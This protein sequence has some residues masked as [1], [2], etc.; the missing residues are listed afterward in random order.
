M[1]NL[2]LNLMSKILALN[3]RSEDQD[4]FQ[5]LDILY[6]YV[7]VMRFGTFFWKANLKCTQLRY[8]DWFSIINK[9]HNCGNWVIAMFT[10]AVT[11][12]A[13]KLKLPASTESGFQNFL[14]KHMISR[15]K[16]KY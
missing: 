2:K 5:S 12:L 11:M 1:T 9:V 14:W 16:S 8:K 3:G 10:I 6:N 7:S 15:Q 4:F 13:E